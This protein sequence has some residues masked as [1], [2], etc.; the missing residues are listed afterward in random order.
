MG[1]Y[2]DFNV[3]KYL[4]T[5]QP[6]PNF[7]PDHTGYAGMDLGGN[8][9]AMAVAL[10][11]QGR[12]VVGGTSVNGGGNADLA[13]G[14][15]N[16][17]G[18]H[19]TGFGPGGYRKLDRGGW[20]EVH[21]LSIQPDGKVLAAGQG[22]GQWVLARYA[23]TGGL[24]TTFGGGSGYVQMYGGSAPARGVGSLSATDLDVSYDPT[25]RRIVLGGA[26]TTGG[27]N[28]STA[29]VVRLHDDGSPDLTFGT[30]GWVDTGVVSSY[31]APVDVVAYGGKVT[32][33][34]PAAD[35]FQPA[36]GSRVVVSRFDAAGTPDLTFGVNGR[37][38]TALGSSWDADGGLALDTTPGHEGEVLVGGTPTGGGLGVVRLGTGNALTVSLNAPT[39]L[40]ATPASTSGMDLSWTNTSAVATAIEVQRSADG[41]TWST[42][43]TITNPATTTYSDT[44]LTEGTAYAYRLRSA[45][46]ALA[47]AWSDLAAA[48]AQPLAPTGLTA[49]AEPD[50]TVGLSW[51]GNSAHAAGYQVFRS[52]DG[53]DFTL[54]ASV[55]AGTT[56][57]SDPTPAYGVANAYCVAAG[58]PRA[59]SA[60]CA[61]P[62]VTPAAPPTAV[63]DSLTVR[64][65]H[66]YVLDD[67]AGLLANDTDPAHLPLTVASYT[68]PSHGAVAPDAT[69]HLVYTPAAGYAGPD[70]FTYVA[71]NGSANSGS[72]M[73]S[74]TVTNNVPTAYSDS[75]T[76][77]ATH[78]VY[79]QGYN[80]ALYPKRPTQTTTRSATTSNKAGPNGSSSRAARTTRCT[81]ASPCSRTGRSCTSPMTVSW[82][83]TGS[84][85][86]CTTGTTPA[87]PRPTRWT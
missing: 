31:Q 37:V 50:G 30:N 53:G 43:A 5:G 14:R 17:D 78:L 82:G 69:G 8:E 51:T 85:T 64:H 49:T 21:S 66:T 48:A 65:G 59:Y 10:D 41:T 55:E 6:D 76:V 11:G 57:Y 34:A 32:V 67:A 4:P 62:A 87:P 83:W 56:T 26:F 77:L 79:T 47:S 58:V 20:D 74:V 1:G 54:I 19:D 73:V 70:S 39:D 33:A 28:P 61:A 9:A 44:G 42:L 68:Q 22:G 40:T 16:A 80:P 12:I 63:D 36:N 38:T 13:V 84:S 3:M 15:F 72:A 25:D 2:G 35:T 45:A 86:R 7:G 46:G 24:D 29:R 81:A 27:S 23:A 18:S 71:T 75:T 52:E 60:A